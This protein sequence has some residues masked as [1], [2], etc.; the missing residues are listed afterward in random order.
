MIIA[1]DFRLAYN[2]AVWIFPLPA[3]PEKITVDVV[4]ELPGFEGRNIRE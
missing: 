3:K 2:K 1:I 4:T